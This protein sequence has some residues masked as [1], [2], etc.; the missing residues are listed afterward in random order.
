[1]RASPND[2]GHSPTTTYYL[3]TSLN[4][5]YS[6]ARARAIPL[7]VSQKV[8]FARRRLDLDFRS[9]FAIFNYCFLIPIY[10]EHQLIAHLQNY[11]ATHEDPA[12]LRVLYCQ[13]RHEQINTNGQEYVTL[14]A[15]YL[16]WQQRRVWERTKKSGQTCS[17]IS[18]CFVLLFPPFCLFWLP[19]SF[20]RLL[21]FIAITMGRSFWLTQEPFCVQFQF[22][23]ISNS[24]FDQNDWPPIRPWLIGGTCDIVAVIVVLSTDIFDRKT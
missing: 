6:I 7:W 20:A 16:I 17:N 2:R 4:Y 5:I 1:M 10:I 14:S 11:E 9:V 3:L 13:W 12:A 22:E 15:I 23:Y 19:G 18:I 21:M 24:I 8:H